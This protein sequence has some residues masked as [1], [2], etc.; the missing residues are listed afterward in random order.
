MYYLFYRDEIIQTS[1][2]KKRKIVKVFSFWIGIN[3]IFVKN[4]SNA[5]RSYFRKY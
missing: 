1:F 2:V 4:H 3:C 5:N